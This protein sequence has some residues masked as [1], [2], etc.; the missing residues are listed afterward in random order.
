VALSLPPPISK[1][2]SPAC[3][4]RV[5]IL[6][7]KFGPKLEGSISNFARRRR[8]ESLETSPPS[9]RARPQSRLI[10]FGMS[11]RPRAA[12]AH[13]RAPNGL[14]FY[15]DQ[16][17]SSFERIAPEKSSRPGTEVP[18]ARASRQQCLPGD[19][20]SAAAEGPCRGRPRPPAHPLALTFTY[21]HTALRRTGRRPADRYDCWPAGRP[22]R[23]SGPTSSPNP[24]LTQIICSRH[25]SASDAATSEMNDRLVAGK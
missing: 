9:E 10:D 13:L 2:S 25:T 14:R 17:I 18:A 15:F 16:L 5:I 12:G 19:S 3:G 1:S 8:S 20:L 22:A 11:W 6:A 7:R 21:M 4:A 23:R 24:T